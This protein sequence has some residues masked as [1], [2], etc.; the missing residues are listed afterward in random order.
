MRALRAALYTRDPVEL[1]FPVFLMIIFNIDFPKLLYM[2]QLCL[3]CYENT[4]ME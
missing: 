2:R 4:N 3:M 1:Y